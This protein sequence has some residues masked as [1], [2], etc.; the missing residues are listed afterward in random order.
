[1]LKFFNLINIS[2]SSQ[3]SQVSVISYFIFDVIN[4]TTLFNAYLIQL[5]SRWKNSNETLRPEGLGILIKYLS[6]SKITLQPNVVLI[7]WKTFYWLTDIYV[8]IVLQKSVTY[9]IAPMRTCYWRVRLKS[10][11]VPT[12]FARRR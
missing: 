7:R 11:L 4:I 9:V 8:I 1:M 2:N 12:Y 10:S 5:T 6:I 3:S